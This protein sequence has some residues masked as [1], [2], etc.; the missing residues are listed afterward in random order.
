M[1][2]FITNRHIPVEFR[3][4]LPDHP[5]D[6]TPFESSIY[7]NV[8]L[9][10]ISISPLKLIHYASVFYQSRFRKNISMRWLNSFLELKTSLSNGSSSEL[11]LSD[12]ESNE[13]Q[14]RS[15]EVLSVGLSVFLMTTL[16]KINNNKI[17]TIEGTGKRCDFS[18][19]KN[20]TEIVFESKGRKNKDAINA[21]IK[22]VFSKK[23][24]HSTQFKYGIISNLP[25]NT[26]SA[27][28]VVVDPKTQENEYTRDKLII[29]LL[30]H[31]T[32]Q[33]YLAGFYRLADLLNIRIQKLLNGSN[34][35]QYEEIPLDYKNIYKIGKA[36]EISYKDFSL[37]T[38]FP[39]SRE[40]GINQI[41]DD[42]VFFLSI[43]KDLIKLLEQQRFNDILEYQCPAYSDNIIETNQRNYFSINMDGSVL[44]FM[45]LDE[46]QE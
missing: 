5:I 17:S 9:D 39:S 30:I 7:N 41:I 31:Y 33:A 45:A 3:E 44:S 14:T 11:Y 4:I 21:A 24:N 25:R 28:M 34:L 42:N 16:L 10:G 15:S 38:F 36:Y 43:D 2:N 1:L 23:I 19:I 32:K 13:F 46:F 6:A 12:T 22:D 35:S 40:L 29:R 37:V 26:E 20:G 18:A 8:K 27:S